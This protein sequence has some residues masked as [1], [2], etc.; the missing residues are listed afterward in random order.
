MRLLTWKIQVTNP[1][2]NFK[3]QDEGIFVIFFPI[4]VSFSPCS[5]A[6]LTIIN[7]DIALYRT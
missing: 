4:S 3:G 5:T 1:T 2:K 7:N 6:I